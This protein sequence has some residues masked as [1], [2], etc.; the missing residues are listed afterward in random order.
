M[1]IDEVVEKCKKHKQLILM[2][3]LLGLFGYYLIWTISQPYNS[4]PD[5]GMKWDI[6]K[7]VSEHNSIPDGRDESIRNPIW[8]ISYAF[9]PILT[10]MICAMFM[11]IASIFTTNQFALVVS[12]R[13]VSTISMTLSIY[14]V[15]KIAD[16]LFKDKEKYKYLF[17]SIIAFQPITAFLASYI[18]NDST[19]ILA[20]TMIIYLWILGLESNWKTKYCVLL[21]LAIGFCALTYYNA[22]GYIFCSVIICLISTVL[23][24]VKVKDI[25]QKAI[26]VSLVAFAVAGRWFVRNAIIYDGDILGT[27]TQNEY[28]D[29][30][31]M[32][33]YKPSTRKTPQNRGESLWH[34]LYDDK[35]IK[36]VIRSFVGIFGYHSIIMSNKIYYSYFLIWL[37]G[38][39]GCILKFK[40]LFF[41]KS[42]EKNKYLL[43][44]IFVI[45]LIIPIVL[46]II[47]S[48]TSDFQPQGRYIMGII[49][50]FT[51]F[52]VT[53]IET[54]LEKFIKSQRMKKII[55]LVLILLVIIISFEA[56]F[57]YV[58]P[59]YKKL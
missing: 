7:Y 3:F 47:Y 57:T 44:Y 19:A 1:M 55:V 35:W 20:T 37:I 13:L 11:K 36:I 31:A 48:Y 43:N 41:Y 14:F 18:N 12:A 33:N 38:G 58:I 22:Y 52:V 46:S 42:E 59:T 25:T 6:C 15:I 26:I 21:G 53:G 45:A 51:Y 16:K 24:K 17:V 9:Q 4:C 23:N 40:E 8:G 32:E 39:I 49:V 5:E 30:Y 28:G 56:I 2:I 54:V 27:R 29:K 50:P 10:Y 34:M